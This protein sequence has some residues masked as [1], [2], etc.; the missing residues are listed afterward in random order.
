MRLSSKLII[1]LLLSTASVVSAQVQAKRPPFDT[2]GGGPF[3]V[4]DLGNL[5]VYF[6]I[7]VLHTA[8]RGT[9]FLYDISYNSQ[10]WSPVTVSG[11]KQWKPADAFGWTNISNAGTGGYITYSVTYNSGTCPINPPY[12]YGSWS[13]TTYNNFVYHDSL[14]FNHPFGYS[15]IY[16]Q[17]P[18]GGTCPPPGAQPP[19][20]VWSGALDGSGFTLYAGP[21]GSSISAYIVTNSGTTLYPPLTTGAPTG[22][23]WSSTDAN[24]N[25]ITES[26]GTWIDTLGNQ[27]A[28]VGTPPNNTTISY[29][30]P[31]GAP[32][33]YTIRYTQYTVRTW[34]QV[35]GVSEYGR[36]SNALV[37]SIALPEDT[38]S[39]PVRYTFTYEQTPAGANCTPLSGTFATYC[40]TGRIA[41]V[42]L[43]TGGTITYT[44]SGGSN[45]IESDGTAAGL[46]RT[47]NPGGQWQYSRSLA[48]STWTTTV[49]DPAG[50]QS[51]INLTKDSSGST[52]SFYETQRQVYQLIGGNQTL[53]STIVT[54]YNAHTTNCPTATVSSPISAKWVTA[55]FPDSSGI[56]N[57]V[58][59]SYDSNSQPTAIGQLDYGIGAPGPL[60]KNTFIT[61]AT[62]GNGIVDR[63]S[64][65][66]VQDNTPNI[67]SKTSF[68]YDEYTTYP[69]QHPS[70]TPQH[71]TI[72]G[73]RGNPTTIKSYINGSTYLT[74]HVQYNDTGT[75][76]KSWDVNGAVSTYTYDTTAQGTTT[77]SCGNSFTTTV[78]S[79]AT[80]NVPS[81]LTASTTWNCTGAVA[82]STTDPNGNAA[83]VNY[84]D[85]Y[86]WRPASAQ[87][88]LSN[89]TNFT[90]TAP[91]SGTPATIESSMLF[92][93]NASI[94]EQLTT[95]DSWGRVQ[96][97]QQQEGPGSAN[98]DS[99]Q[100]FY[101]S[102]GR[103]YQTS[104]PSVAGAGQGGT[105]ARSTTS[106]D[107]L[108]RV[109]QIQDGNNGYISYS[110]N[111]ND[112]LTVNG[113]APAG[114]SLKRKQIQYD[115]TGRL[116][117]VCEITAGT[118]QAPAGS[119]SQNT[120]LPSP[121]GAGYLTAYTYDYSNG[122]R[123]MTVTQNAQAA[124]GSRQ[125]RTYL[126]DLLG[127]LVSETN[128]ETGNQTPGTTTY[129]YDTDPASV[130]PGPYTSGD[131]IKRVDNRGNITCYQYD[132]LHRV[133]SISYPASSPDASNTPSKTFIYDAATY[134]GTAMSNPKGHL[135]EA[136]T[137]SSGSKTTDEFFSYSVRGELQD[138]WECTPHS[139]TNG[140]AS[141]SNY[142]HVTAGYWANGVLNTLSSNIS[143][144]PNQTYSPDGMGRP[145]GV[146]A[147]SN[148][149]P[150]VVS[151]TVYDL[152]NNKTT[153]TYGSTD[154]DVFTFDPN[155][156]RLATYK[157]N[158]GSN[159]DTG[160]LGW[161][162][163][164]SLGT[165]A[166][167]DTVPGTSDTQTCNFTHDD[168]SRVASAVCLNGQTTK[169]NQT[170]SYDAFGNITKNA[171][172]GII[173]N[174]TYTTNNTN[175]FLSLPGA[176][177]T[178]DNDGRL[179]YDGTNHYTWDAES[180][181]YTV[182]TAPNSTTITYDAIGRVV[183][184]KVGTAYTQVVYSPA[185][186]K[187]AVMNAQ[188]MLK[189]YVPLPGGG[190]AVYTSTGLTYYRHSDHLGSSRLATTPNQTMYSST[191][192]A[193]Y[194][195][196]YAQ[197]GS[198]DLNFTGQDQ[199]TA[200]GM[201]DFY[202]RRFTTTSGRWLTPDPAGPG[203]VDPANPQTWN[204]YAYVM[205]SPLNLIDPLGEEAYDSSC[206]LLGDMCWGPLANLA[207][208]FGF[209]DPFLWIGIDVTQGN[210]GDI[211]APRI[212]DA[213]LMYGDQLPDFPNLPP[214]NPPLP[215]KPPII[216]C[217]QQLFGVTAIS[218]HPIDGPADRAGS[219]TGSMAGIFNG[220]GKPRLPGPYQFSVAANN[221]LTVQ[222]ITMIYKAGGN[223]VAPGTAIGGLT[224]YRNPFVT[225]VGNDL[226]LAQA[227]DTQLW[228]L[229]NALGAITG[230]KIPSVWNTNMGP[231]NNEPGSKLLQCIKSAK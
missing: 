180:N 162:S 230:Q 80:P 150:N 206:A 203:A 146:T 52:Q 35:S 165:L 19:G 223:T 208:M 134:N 67:L 183:E 159:S 27:L 133:S 175:Q 132:N 195:E 119:C 207:T 15:G 192:Y 147:N 112:V 151:S 178:Y 216:D 14:G 149:N 220:F 228:E 215:R 50:N 11:T 32:A 40:V 7:P 197:A 187:L 153:V 221:G 219:F 62:L 96:F 22:G 38:P 72:T 186:G 143:G 105:G 46:T 145:S 12:S 140:C 26:G 136:Y 190:T 81:G 79:P 171:T 108:G 154:T 61:Y 194:G 100:V 20:T 202:A 29:K 199:D 227:Q 65:I 160:T 97:S 120:P 23:S 181:L 21:P 68:T 173:F 170:F 16:T 163:N 69:L 18:G 184:K 63:P 177:P 193:P 131:L 36:T 198:T 124:Q 94:S 152:A 83:S 55:Q 28:L 5:T 76:Y 123:R 70:G 93:G 9:P 49:I 222:T 77:K 57:K 214:F 144:L 102:L 137:G 176:T 2:Y 116:S 169:W 84:S 166:I 157:F 109:A 174:P 126:Y 37:D 111:G 13:Q 78:T 148:Q 128:P 25:M 58:L 179:T 217:V 98:Y 196:P 24:G 6:S 224:D 85:P 54:C 125:T 212:G 34:F 155:T 47:V 74:R 129:F 33:S 71:T 231:A 118:A 141:V 113:P 86:Y 135:V 121:P 156:G 51:L 161:N 31:S 229:G 43:P 92:N 139:G 189:A 127:R 200:T 82:L 60:L 211:E 3:D 39:H 17:S 91:G 59:V 41:S 107:P 75:V 210:V 204:R 95:L 110:Y 1:A 115:G 88:A 103:P 167:N 117:S 101:D 90:Y 168:L 218:F 56:Q 10:V 30:A 201:H 188:T 209:A 64:L 225:W 73:D 8:G 104:M 226:P 48:G 122:Y 42:T 164:G 205:N 172:V 130:C 44:Y 66:T 89:T 53:L 213:F 99:T 114:E 191:A 106:F 45:G 158:V 182:D 142:Y 4:V 138:V 87:D 185:G